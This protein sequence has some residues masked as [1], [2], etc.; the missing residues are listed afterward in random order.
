MRKCTSNL[1]AVWG[2]LE[3]ALGRHFQGKYTESVL[4][5]GKNDVFELVKFE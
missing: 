5:G 3:Q 2:A 4:C 1:G